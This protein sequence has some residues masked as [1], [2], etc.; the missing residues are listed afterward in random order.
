MNYNTQNEKI[1][2]ITEKTS[3]ENSCNSRNGT[4]R[5]LLVFIRE[6]PAGQWDEACA[7]E[8]PSCE[9]IKRAG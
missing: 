4:D 1:K 6:V 7:C 3:G 8:S 9:E 2:S 5:T